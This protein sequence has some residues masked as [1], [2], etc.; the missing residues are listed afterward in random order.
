[1]V[2]GCIRTYPRRFVGNEVCKLFKETGIEVT[3]LLISIID[4]LLTKYRTDIPTKFDS[5]ELIGKIYSEARELYN[6]KSK[7]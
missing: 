2:T 4:G 3:E 5:P 1:M 7:S 6:M